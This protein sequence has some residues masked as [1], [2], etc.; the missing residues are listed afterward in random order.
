ML[1]DRARRVIVT[2][3]ALALALYART[4]TW[5]RCLGGPLP[6]TDDTDGH[7]HLVRALET[8][9]SGLRVPSFDPWLTWPHG[10]SAPWPPGFDQFLA[11][12]PW[13]MGLKHDPVAAERVM[14]VMPLLVG[15]AVVLVTMDLARRLAPSPDRAD[16]TALVAGALVATNPQAA[17]TTEVG[18]TDHHGAEMLFAGLLVR[19]M[20]AWR[21]DL[22]RRDALRWELAGVAIFVVGTHVYTGVVLYGGIALGLVALARLTSPAMPVSRMGTGALA[23]TVSALALVALDWGWIASHRPWFH[24][25]QLS[26][27]QPGL[28]VVTAVAAHAV[29]LA[30]RRETVAQRWRALVPYIAGALGLGVLAFALSPGARAALH[31]GVVRWLGRRDPWMDRIA[32]SRPLF[33]RIPTVRADWRRSVALAAWQ[34]PWVPVAAVI[35]LRPMVRLRRVLVGGWLAAFVVLAMTQMRFGRPLVPAMVVIEALALVAIGERL[36]RWKGDAR[37]W[38]AGLCAAMLTL[39]P[40]IWEVLRTRSPMPSPI[41]Q[42]G[43]FLRTLPAPQGRG[44]G[45]GVL[46]SWDRSHDIRDLARRPQV[47]SGFGPYVGLA[48]F[49]AS[50]R[51][52][53]GSAAGMADFMASTDAGHLVI[54][55]RQF[56]KMRD[57]QGG[58]FLRTGPR[59]ASPSPSFL[60]A[61]GAAVLAF[62]GGGDPDEGVAHAE[63]F[64]PVFAVDEPWPDVQP[65]VPSLWVYA[66]VPGARI[67]GAARDGA[68]VELTVTLVVRGAPRPWRAWTVAQGGHFAL[69]VPLPTGHR[70]A[71]V[72]TGERYTVRIDGRDVGELAVPAEAVYEGRTLRVP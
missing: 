55:A 60:R 24:P 51:A 10:A 18:G 22:D 57:T 41:M 38:S 37:V 42:A 59:G 36:A 31:E 46:A 5:D 56:Q 40:V 69:T 65:A 17:V 6:V 4:R 25:L 35:A 43:F 21:A 66:R 50:E 61:Q 16:V 68:R 44:T 13:V 20:L 26:L 48:Q 11:F 14:M 67:E 58:A 33:D 3:A 39:D 49:E 28:L 45:A 34:T 47:L 27:L 7:Y 30:S 63:H 62:G 32:E 71:T 54:G 70:T 15:V 12:G 8:L 2:F 1:S 29:G 9:R 52:L 72:G 23:T 53:H 19:W 64:L